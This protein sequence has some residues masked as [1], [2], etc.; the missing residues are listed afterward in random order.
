MNAEVLS[1]DHVTCF[2]VK[3]NDEAAWARFFKGHTVSLKTK[4]LNML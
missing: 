3:D 4:Q 2:Q 1:I